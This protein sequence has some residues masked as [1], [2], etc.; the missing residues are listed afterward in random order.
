MSLGTII[1]CIAV[2]VY[3]ASCIYAWKRLNKRA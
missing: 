2:V 3:I 1:V